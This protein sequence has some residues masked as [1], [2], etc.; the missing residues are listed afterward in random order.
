MDTVTY[1]I[2][3]DDNKVINLYIFAEEDENLAEQIRNEFGFTTGVWSLDNT[4]EVNG[5]YLSGTFVEP[6]PYPSWILNKTD[7][8]WKAPKPKP[9][10]GVWYWDED[11][12]S[13]IEFVS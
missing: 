13:W 3:D 11:S 2:L 8:V 6:S 12:L 5:Y 1:A 9:D 7:K 10:S 4:A